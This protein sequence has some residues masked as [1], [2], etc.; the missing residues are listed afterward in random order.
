MDQIR[1]ASLFNPPAANSLSPVGKH[2]ADDEER[3]GQR[4][5]DV[6]AASHGA[7]NARQTGHERAV[8]GERHKG[9]ATDGETLTDGGRRVARGVQGVGLLAHLFVRV[10][11]IRWG[12]LYSTS[13]VSGNGMKVQ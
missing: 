9:G 3:E 2:G 10:A 12:V 8:E 5:Q 11:F 7:S 13:R 1:S 4:L 6:N